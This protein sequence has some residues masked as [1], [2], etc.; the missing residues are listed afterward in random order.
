MN[1]IMEVKK[2]NNNS[3]LFEEEFNNLKKFYIFK[4]EH[5]VHRF[6]KLHSGIII[7]LKK[8][9]PYLGHYFPNG[10]FE[11]EFDPD[12]SGSW[13][14]VL[15]VNIMVDRKTFNNGCTE[16]IDSINREFRPLRKKLGLLG[17]VLLM[18]KING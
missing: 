1:E 14:D 17:E 2:L 7:L 12:L 3:K 15:L 4:S 11:L 13:F 10:I 9:E 6:I 18:E 5:E 8:F 16:H